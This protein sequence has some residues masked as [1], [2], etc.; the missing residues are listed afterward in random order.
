MQQVVMLVEDDEDFR[1]VV[2][3]AL[4]ARFAVTVVQANDGQHAL[5]LVAKGLRPDLVIS[6][7]KMPK[8][9][10]FAFARALGAIGFT[11][12]LIFMTGLEAEQLV[13]EAFGLGGFDFVNK[14]L[15]ESF[16]EAVGNALA[17]VNLKWDINPRRVA[18]DTDSA[19]VKDATAP[20][21]PKNKAS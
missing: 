2:Q 15:D 4:V 8:M 14:P 6:D 21:D 17:L 3:G 7:F 13:K 9:D 1:H 11:C 18:G 19:E 16:F 5:E 20:V 10:G 12:P